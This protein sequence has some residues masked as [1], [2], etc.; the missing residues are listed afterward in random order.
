[1]EKE[2]D[3]PIER[4]YIYKIVHGGLGPILTLFFGKSILLFFFFFFVVKKDNILD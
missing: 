3:P 1:M 4:W 2:C